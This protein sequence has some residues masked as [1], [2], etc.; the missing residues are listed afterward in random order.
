MKTHTNPSPHQ[1]LAF[2]LTLLLASAILGFTGR[3][4]GENYKTRISP[5]WSTDNTYFWYRNNLAKGTREFVLV[6]LTKGTREPAF[7]L[8]LIHI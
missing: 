3:A 8:S 5:Q 2:A 6:D 7:A 4:Q 1:S